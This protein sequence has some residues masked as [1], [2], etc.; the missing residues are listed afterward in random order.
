MM[1]NK[2]SFGFCE[3]ETISH[4]IQELIANNLLGV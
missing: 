3:N 2:N 4:R 1:M